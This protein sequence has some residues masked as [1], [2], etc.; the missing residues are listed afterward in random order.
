MTKIKVALIIDSL[1]SGGKERRLV[2]LLKG[3]AHREE[4]QAELV[5]LSDTVYF[6]DVL[7][8]NIPIHY[9]KRKSAKDFSI[10]SRLHKVLKSFGPDLVHSF[11]SMSS[12]YA[13]PVTQWL[14][15]PLINAMISNAPDHI[16]LFS[17]LWVRSKLTFPFSKAIVANSQAGLRAYKVNPQK[18]HCIRNGFNFQRMEDLDPAAQIKQS[19]NINTPK[20]VGMVATF[21]NK[22]DYATY[23]LAAQDILKQNSEVTFICVGSG[24]TM[25]SCQELVDQAWQDKILFLGNQKN[26]ES[27]VNTFTIG[28]LATFTEGISN[29]ILEYMALGKPVVASEGGG[30]N[31]LVKDGING[32]LVPSGSVELMAEKIK[33]L[34]EDDRLAQQMGAKSR[35]IVE[36]EYSIDKM[37]SDTIALYKKIKNA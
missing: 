37:I 7:T 29:S 31:E 9:L 30:T 27:I 8:L 14:G 12:I 19:F 20:V 15:I 36:Q 23:V 16:G 21:S 3:F 2:E 22:K 25:A 24:P 10:Y 6:E 33:L 18:A 5:V 35:E 17:R 32:Y 4:V 11:E 28:V 34:L 1:Q 13:F 26:I